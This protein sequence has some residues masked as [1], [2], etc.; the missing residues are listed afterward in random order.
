M[1]DKAKLSFSGKAY[2]NRKNEA[3]MNV[4]GLQADF[5]KIVEGDKPATAALIKSIG[6]V[7]KE[8]A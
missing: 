6:E 1:A 5:A 8:K 3:R 2:R 4:S 7:L